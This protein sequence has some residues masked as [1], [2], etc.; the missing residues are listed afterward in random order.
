M[1]FIAPALPL[2][3]AAPRAGAEPAF[4][5]PRESYEGWGKWNATT[6][7]EHYADFVEFFFSQVFTEPHS[8]KQREDAVGWGL[9]TDAETLVATQLHATG[10]TRRA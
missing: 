9:E 5:Q 4:T 8:T 1:V 2:P 6:G 10:A 7:V 3:P